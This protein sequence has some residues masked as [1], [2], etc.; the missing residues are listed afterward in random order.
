VG[1]AGNTKGTAA[2]GTDPPQRGRCVANDVAYA[3]YVCWGNQVPGTT[4]HLLYHHQTP[5]CYTAPSRRRLRH[6]MW[7]GSPERY[8]QCFH[9]YAKRCSQ[10]LR[11]VTRQ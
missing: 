3:M 1:V 4:L 10:A 2:G 8:G 11:T 7:Y 6:T 5:R 9:A